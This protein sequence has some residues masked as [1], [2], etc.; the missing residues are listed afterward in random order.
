[1]LNL[2]DLK[3]E[4]GL[5]Y[6]FISHDLNVV[7]FISDRVMVM[8]LGKVV[9]IGPV[10]ALFEPAPHP[11]TRALLSRCRRWIPTGAPRRRRWPAIRRTRSIRRPAA[12]STRAARSPKRL[13][14]HGAARCWAT[15][16]DTRG[17][18][19]HGR[20]V[21]QRAA[22]RERGMTEAAMAAS[23]DRRHPRPHGDLHRRAAA[24][25]CGQRRRLH[26]RERGEVV[27]LIGESGSGKSVTLRA[28]LRLHP[29]A[30]RPR[31]EGSIRVAGATCSRCA[32][33]RWRTSAA[34]SC[35]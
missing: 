16:P 28:L 30:A 20:P 32:A 33:A 19:P 8:Y 3:E 24:G 1:M 18:L 4:F 29:P 12:A 34:A 10:E 27:A 23:A 9:E 6:V 7:R 17:R 25:A 35:R 13:R 31:I 5:T 21:P 22:S 2:L 26:A 15:G 11:Y 14:A